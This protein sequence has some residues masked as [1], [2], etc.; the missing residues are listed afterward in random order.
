MSILCP[1]NYM[2]GI[3]DEALCGRDLCSLEKNCPYPKYK[4]TAVKSDRPIKIHDT[5]RRCSKDH[6][7][8]VFF[9]N[10]CPLC[11]AH[12]ISEDRVKIQIKLRDKLREKIAFLEN[13]PSEI[14]Y[15]RRL[16]GDLVQKLARANDT[17]DSLECDLQ[18]ERQERINEVRNTAAAGLVA[19]AR[20]NHYAVNLQREIKR[21]KK[22]VLMNHEYMEKFRQ[23]IQAEHARR[24]QSEEIFARRFPYSY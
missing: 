13:I 21:L 17:I 22:V 24:I 2:L 20:T 3:G 10:E 18:N 19:F 15:I 7:P 11:E 4:T 9:N 12:Q 5:S 6:K 14:K 23:D 1:G 16:N 8:I